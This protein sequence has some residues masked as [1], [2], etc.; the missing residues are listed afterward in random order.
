MTITADSLMELSIFRMICLSRVFNCV[1]W[2]YSIL[3]L[4]NE[5]FRTIGQAIS[6][7]FTNVKNMLHEIIDKDN[8]DDANRLHAHIKVP[9]KLRGFSS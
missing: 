3:L 6:N 9:L 5:T 4:F 7:W 1:N 8:R 2:V